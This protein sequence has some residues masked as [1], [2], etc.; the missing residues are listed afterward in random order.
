MSKVILENADV[1]SFYGKSAEPI[2]ACVMEAY[3]E[4]MKDSKVE[5]IFK[6]ETTENWAEKYT[7]STGI[8]NMKKVA[9]NGVAPRTDFKEGYSKVITPDEFKLEI[10]VEKKMVEDD[11]IG[12]IKNMQTR[13][14]NSA[15]RSR[16]VF[17]AMIID[18]ANKLV[19]TYEDETFDL[20]IADGKALVATDHPSKTGGAAQSN[21]YNAALTYD[22]F[23]KIKSKMSMFKDD[24]GNLL[25][26]QADTLIIPEDATM[27]QTAFAIIGSLTQDQVTNAHQ[28]KANPYTGTVKV[29]VWKYLNGM[30][31]NA[32]SAT[33]K[34]WYLMDSQYNETYNGLVFLDR[35]A[36]T[37]KMFVDEK[38]DE[39]ISKIRARFGACGNDWRCIIGCLAGDTGATAVS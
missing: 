8:G 30:T 29:I 5:K 35:I 1:D 6:M 17:G 19:G 22:N 31:V 4:Y 23:A 12:D 7:Y 24:N 27:I 16:E 11:K 36:P 20:T 26:V 3:E 39:Q 38:T 34:A 2:K 18:N 28:F 37:V 9:G 21:Y 25:S 33:A 32:G 13:L 10:S 15:Y 14:V